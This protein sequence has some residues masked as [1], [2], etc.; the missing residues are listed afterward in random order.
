MTYKETW[1][2]DWLLDLLDTAF[3]VLDYNCS[4]LL[5]AEWVETYSVTFNLQVFLTQSSV[6]RVGLETVE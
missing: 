4:Y 3:T 2:F 1:G 5:M 6:N